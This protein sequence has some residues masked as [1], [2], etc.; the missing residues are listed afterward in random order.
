MPYFHVDDGFHGHKKV[1][2]LGI[3]DFAALALWTVA[4]SWTSDNLEDGF[5][6]DYIA[7]KMHPDYKEF[8]TALVRVGLWEIAEKGGE[9]GWQFHDWNDPGRNPTSE[10]VLKERAANAERQREFRSRVK[11]T[12]PKGDKP[13]TVSEPEGAVQPEPPMGDGGS[14]AVTAPLVTGGV[15]DPVPFRS[16]PFR[17]NEENPST[18]PTASP[19]DAAPSEAEAGKKGRKPKAPKV[20]RDLP[21]QRAD[22]DAL[23]QRLVDLM[24]ANDCREPT[25]TKTWRTEARLLLDND[26]VKGKHISFDQALWLLEW[27]QRSKFWRKNIHSM[28]T[29]REKF[30]RLRQDSEDEWAVKQQRFGGASAR[31]STTTQIVEQNL[32]LIEQ[33]AAEDGIDLATVLH[34]PGQRRELTG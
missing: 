9:A 19:S 33:M 18:S 1:A 7:A 29:F 10:Q 16:V 21:G 23:C 3:E 28:P 12:K 5:V 11:G 31:P 26:K 14:N 22:V 4:G 15:C 32:S 20:E 8:A 6:P 24:V 34:F 30:D 17:S 25:I 27:C 13:P 2:R